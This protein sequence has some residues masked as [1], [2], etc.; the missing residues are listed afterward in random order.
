MCKGQGELTISE[1]TPGRGGQRLGG[2]V[3]PDGQSGPQSLIWGGEEAQ[4]GGDNFALGARP[5][6]YNVTQP[7][8]IVK[9]ICCK[10]SYTGCPKKNA[11]LCSKAP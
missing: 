10:I 11:L 6:E 5:K 4:G 8:F 2:S 9:I 3:P 7:R 1:A